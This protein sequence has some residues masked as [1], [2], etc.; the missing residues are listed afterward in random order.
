M[1]AGGDE[2]LDTNDLQN[3]ELVGLQSHA[4]AAWFSVDMVDAEMAWEAKPSGRR[5]RQQ[6]YSDAAIQACLTIKVLSGYCP[7]LGQR[8]IQ[9]FCV[10]GSDRIQNLP[11]RKYTD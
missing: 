7:A 3:Q 11:S 2:Q 6:V 8:L 5:G 1:R 9:P 10:R 4:E